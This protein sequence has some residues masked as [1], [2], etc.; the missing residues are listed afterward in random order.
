[1]RECHPLVP[2][3]RCTSL[4]SHSARKP[5]S[6]FIDKLFTYLYTVGG[7][8]F[9]DEAFG[10]AFRE[11]GPEHDGRRGHL[12]GVDGRPGGGGPGAQGPDPRGHRHLRHGRPLPPARL[13]HH[14]RGRLQSRP[15]HGGESSTSYRGVGA[16]RNNQMGSQNE[17]TYVFKYSTLFALLLH[18]QEYRK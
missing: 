14:A 8:A 7:V 17:V 5:F 15:D 9:N 16:R 13:Q 11:V 3:G 4:T 2:L 1:M 6:A 10:L 18:H 12:Q